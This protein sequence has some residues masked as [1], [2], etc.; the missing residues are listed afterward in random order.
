MA[1]FFPFFFIFKIITAWNFVLL[2]PPSLKIYPRSLFV[3]F[4]KNCSNVINANLSI[5]IIVRILDWRGSR[6]NSIVFNL[7]KNEFLTFRR[8]R[9]LISISI[10]FFF[11][12]SKLLEY[13]FHANNIITP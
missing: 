5:S 2:S 11:L 7:V 10:I 1:F 9:K 3:I 8:R 13:K 12:L 4:F 6:K